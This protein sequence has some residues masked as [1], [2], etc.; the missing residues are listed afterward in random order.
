LSLAALI[1]FNDIHK[2]HIFQ[3]CPFH[4]GHEGFKEEH[5]YRAL[6]LRMHIAAVATIVRII[7]FFQFIAVARMVSCQMFSNDQGQS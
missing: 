4:F 2:Q 7:L 1:R 5:F 6:M 3:Y